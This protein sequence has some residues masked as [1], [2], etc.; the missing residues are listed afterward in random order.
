ML[1]STLRDAISKYDESK[2]L[3]RHYVTGDESHV[4][5]LQ[6]FLKKHMYTGES[7]HDEALPELV[8]ILLSKSS[9]GQASSACFTEIADKFG[10]M[11]V[12]SGMARAGLTTPRY[13]A[14]IERH[15]N[16]A[17]AL[18]RWLKV[19]AEHGIRFEDYLPYLEN[20][21]IPERFYPTFEYLMRQ[22]KEA[23]EA[24]GSRSKR[25]RVQEILSIFTALKKLG[26]TADMAIFGSSPENRSP[27]IPSMSKVLNC[28]EIITHIAIHEHTLDAEMLHR[29][30]NEV[31]D[32]EKFLSSLRIYGVP[33]LDL[34]L[35]R[36]N[37]IPSDPISKAFFVNYKIHADSPQS[38]SVAFLTI[39]EEART[40]AVNAWIKLNAAS[41]G[42]LLSPPLF[43]K[44]Q[45]APNLA[46]AWQETV[47][48]IN[49]VFPEDMREAQLSLAATSC[50]NPRVT[51]PVDFLQSITILAKRGQLDEERLRRLCDND[52]AVEARKIL[53]ALQLLDSHAK[54]DSINADS[55]MIDP[56]NGPQLASDL[57][58]VEAVEIPASEESSLFDVILV[59]PSR[60][61][62][63]LFRPDSPSREQMAACSTSS[64]AS[65]SYSGDRS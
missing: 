9:A 20:I 54:L 23:I 1:I 30:C 19:F 38:A 52:R 37:N 50:A 65:C 58:G 61:G 26:I 10:G 2:G 6:E 53:I 42:S 11:E 13:L 62:L 31:N 21:S 7:L 40:N 44:L 15:P 49:H 28:R 25:L 33:A 39:T 8:N 18:V 41:H 36:Q 64:G 3:L 14:F 27:L 43:K 56:G 22:L 16:N 35:R 17:E 45:D 63:G 32:P 46:T 57:C 51:H 59:S 24:P 29:I 60:D 5:L 48:C 12:L 4:Q 34:L 47:E 55:V